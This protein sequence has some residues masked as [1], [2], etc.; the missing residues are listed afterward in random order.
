MNMPLPSL[1]P[2]AF[3]PPAPGSRGFMQCRFIP[4]ILAGLM[5]VFSLGITHSLWAQAKQD[6]AQKLQVIF[7]ISTHETIGRIMQR[8]NAYEQILR[9][10]RGLFAGSTEVTH[11]EFHSYVSALRLDEH[12]PGVQG[13]GYAEIVPKAQKASHVDAIRKKGFPEYKINPE[14]E[15]DFYTSIVE[16]EP[17]SG[18]NL[19]AFGYDMYTNPVRR[20]AMML[21]RDQGKAALS[22]K[23]TLVQEGEQGVQP[24][25]LMYLPVYRRGMPTETVENRRAAIVGWVYAPFRVNDLMQG[26]RDALSGDLDI[27]IY[28]DGTMSAQSQLYGGSAVGAGR[29]VADLSLQ[30]ATQRIEI[31]GRAWTVAISSL[32]AFETRVDT[33]RPK[34]IATAGIL[35]SLLLS[36]LIW[37]LATGRARALALATEMT[38]ELKESE[39]WLNLALQSA[40]LGI[41]DWDIKQ[42]TVVRSARHDQIY[43]YDAPVPEWSLQTFLNHLPP[44]DRERAQERIRECWD[45][46]RMDMVFR[47]IQPGGALRWVSVKGSVL[48]DKRGQPARQIGMVADITELKQAEDILR[49]AHDELEIRV[50][51]RTADLQKTNERLNAEISE[52]NRVEADLRASR[53]RLA[54]IFDAMTEGLVVQARDGSFMECNAAAERILGLSAG[55]LAATDTLDRLVPTVHEDGSPFPGNLHPAAVSLRTGLP[56]RDVVM[57][58]KKA[59]GNLTWVS[60]NTE[61]LFDSEGK[62]SMVVSNLSDITGKKHSEEMIWNQANFDALTGLPNRRLFYDHLRQGIRT[63]HRTGLPL[64]LIFLDLD[65]FKDV[66][67]TLGHD[68][69][70]IL[71]KEAAQR[72]QSCVRETDTVARLGGDEF[73]IIMGELRNPGHIAFVAQ[74]ILQKMAEPFHLGIETAH[75]SA[76]I[77]I[78][79]YPEDASDAD[80]LLRNADQAMYAAKNL[81]R[82]RY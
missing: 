24:G 34:V 40:Q 57:G 1:S 65:R 15:R 60:I 67:D 32:P 44:E 51:Q 62:V 78:T 23:V 38:G 11:D 12:Y 22:G 10:L 53:E 5:L 75:I 48:Y 7:D 45:T 31:G 33:D 82:N 64:A 46:G 19:R 52:R 42:D 16:I 63:A 81:G 68:T 21:A 27:R 8:M 37:L 25:F 59:D 80:V 73:T 26:M 13:V 30:Q 29:R 4:Q 43:G 41:V 17:F 2:I 14:D 56:A 35:A 28:D 20:A 61:L 47:I 54:S 58:L 36:L 66:N 6:A 18:M 50:R 76:S 69:G 70:D 74:K 39:K 55:Q 71:L 3:P 79:L 49:K 9:G 77:G 72:L